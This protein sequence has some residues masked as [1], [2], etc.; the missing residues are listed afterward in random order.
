MISRKRLKKELK[1]DEIEELYLATIREAN[2]DTNDST[3]SASQ[4]Q[5]FNNSTKSPNGFERITGQY[6]E[7]NYP[8]RCLLH[9]QWT[10]RFH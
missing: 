1:R 5:Q 6:S 9:D 4:H 3:E 7:K 10:I 2:D 8:H